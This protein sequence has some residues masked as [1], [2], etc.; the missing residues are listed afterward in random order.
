M[1]ILLYSDL[2]ISKTSSILPQHSTDPKYTY[3]QQM[4]IDTAVILKRVIETYK[5]DLMVNLRGYF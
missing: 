5:P 1:K 2:H 3:R 4:I